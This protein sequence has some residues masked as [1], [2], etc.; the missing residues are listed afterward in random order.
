MHSHVTCIRTACVRTMSKRDVNSTTQPIDQ[1]GR[2]Q[3][4]LRSH[5]NDNSNGNDSW[6]S[7]PASQPASRPASQP[8]S[9]PAVQKLPMIG[10]SNSGLLGL[11]CAKPYC[12]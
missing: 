3:P 9:Q 8:A 1:P 11:L 5:S 7:Q 10:G 6:S 12:A 2:A 4:Q